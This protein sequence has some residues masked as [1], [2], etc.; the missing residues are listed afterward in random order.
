MSSAGISRLAEALSHMVESP[1]GRSAVDL[2]HHIAD[3]LAVLCADPVY[4]VFYGAIVSASAG[5]S[6]RA[7]SRFEILIPGTVECGGEVL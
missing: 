6:G 3:L 5:P 2:V 1:G 4:K 7:G